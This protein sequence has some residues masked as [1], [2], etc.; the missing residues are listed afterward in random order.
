MTV[1]TLGE[2]FDEGPDAFLDSAA[3]MENL[4]LVI[5][6]DT[7]IAHLAGA[8]GRPVWVALKHVPD[9]RWMLERP[10]SPW[11]P[12][13]RLFRQRARGD[14]K[15]V[16]AE[17]EREVID[18]LGQRDSSKTTTLQGGSPPKPSEDPLAKQLQIK[19]QQA[20][21]LHQ[22]GQLLEADAI[23]QEILQAQPQHFDSLNLSGLIALQT[24]NHELAVQLIGKAIR[25]NPEVASA[26]NYLG[27]AQ[28]G[29]K[30]L[31]EAVA[32]YDKAL[33][34]NIRYAEAYNN[35]GNTLRNL[36]RLGE[37]VA[38]FDQALSLNPDYAEA[39][40]NRGNVLKDLKRLDE[41]V[42]SYG[43]ALEL[44]PN[45]LEAYV[46]RGN[47]LRDLK[48]LDEAVASYDKAI[49]LNSN[50]P[51][52]Y[53]N[54]GVALRDL[55]QPDEALASYEKALSLQSGYAEAHNNRGNVLRDLQRPDE[56][57]A[58]YN[59]AL[60]LNPDYAE[61][62]N[63]RGTAQKDLK[64]PDEALA[65]Y[66]EALSL[67][68]DYAEAHNNR[69]MALL[70]VGRFELGWRDYEWRKLMKEPSGNRSFAKPAWL[71]KEPIAGKTVL[72]HAE[73]GL[74]DTI[75]FCRYLPLLEKAG[76][77]VLLLPQGPLS[78]L[79][80]SLPCSAQ[81][82]NA[83][84]P[85]ATFDYHCPLLSLP[86]AFNTTL[87]TIPSQM[88]Y[89]QADPERVDRWKHRLGRIGFKIGVAWQGTSKAKVD[90]GRSFAV[91]ELFGL[92]QLAGV[93]LISLQ[94]AE[95]REQL[96]HLPAGMTVETLG[97]DFDE[98]P[99]AFLDSAAVME[100]LDLVI[101]SDTAIA[102]L[103]GALGRPVWVALKHVPD[104]RWMLERPDSPWYPT[105][106]LFRQRARGDWKGVFAEIER[107]VIDYLGQR[108]SS[109]T[110]TLQGGSPTKPSEDP[111]AKQLQIK[112][113]QAMALHQK[114][115]LLEA[116]AIYQEILQAQPQNFDSLQ[117]G[118]VFAAQ[119]GNYEL[120]ARLLREA[121]KVNAD[122]ASAHNNLANALF[123]LR[124]LD[125]AVASYGKALALRPD[126]A[127][128]YNN[129]GNALLGLNRLD[130]ALA[131]FD[132]ALSLK[133]DFWSAHYG[134]GN[135]LKDL[136]RFDEALAHYDKAL[137]LKPDYL[138]AHVNRGTVLQ[139]FKRLE[140]ALGSYEQALLLDPDHAHAHNNRGNALLELKRLD[141]AVASYDKALSLK[142]DYAEAYNNRAAALQ[143]LE[144]FGAALSCYDKALE[145][146]PGYVE[147]HC[148][149]GN[150]LLRLKRLEEAL[151]SYDK[152]MSLDPEYNSLFGTFLH[153]KMMLCEWLSLSECLTKLE[154]DLSATHKVIPPLAVLGLLDLP[155]LQRK[156][157]QVYAQAKY[158]RSQVLGPIKRRPPDGKIRVGYY[159]ADF[160]NHA[161]AYLVAELF[162]AHDTD[163]FQLY[164]FSFGP[165]AH[166]DMRRRISAAFHQF[167]DVRGKSDREVAELSR[168]LGID[169]AIDLKGF[170]QD[171]RPGV[172]A[173]L[174][175]ASDQ[176]SWLSR[177]YG[178]RIHRLHYRRQDRHT[179]GQQVLL[180]GEGRLFAAQL[181]GEQFEAADFRSRPHQA[182]TWTA[183]LW[184]CLLLLQQQLQDTARDL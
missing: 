152:A 179:G 135:V 124:Q 32:S 127:A 76:A 46:N 68:P 83:D 75:Q 84:D 171:S 105:M 2:D 176:L 172:F 19:F 1:E 133:A 169:I 113:Q 184:V 116:D 60:S 117:M 98:G 79:M 155:E 118:G 9:W 180:H 96:D 31:N 147:A 77:K 48:R 8:L 63:N 28:H 101:S 35:R 102:H 62:Y 164:A 16:F 11:Y 22:K 12:T 38:D 106:R 131:D 181:S 59:Q 27:N 121:I 108:D 56:A 95:G 177:N 42:A 67:K 148:N 23:Y 6:S 115:Q 51:E 144:Q 159:S 66:D 78:Q 7:A 94:K 13:M 18:Y 21:A 89:L 25:A 61:A 50:S 134:R 40:Y 41:A 39:Y 57:L 43:R 137:A 158:P 110:T 154:A 149:R 34:L 81:I 85:A 103:A 55:D 142:P 120:A 167:I 157:A 175:S 47:V 36:D 170:T 160:H 138:A 37:A 119:S 153:T 53:N 17:I 90:I 86:L 162:E 64:R 139:G 80:R 92:S 129:R 111:L 141:E 29:L 5:S 65:S 58:S 33:A 104:W 126:Y 72:I 163:E 30:R 122:V 130:E 54:R 45:F 146:N 74:G 52:A 174:R 99:D 14:W 69:G 24:G 143:D 87:Q 97:E 182:G 112:F 161:T 132:K 150:A 128:A 178:R 123:E 109:K 168:E 20:M 151:S 71:G 49:S 145:I 10:D 173:G 70:L 44:N 125:E 100:N 183:G 88:P 166:D 107:E 136:R 82:L 73:Q 156:A 3:V 165:E 114:G 26:Y 140:E 93:R 91:S 15:G 4:D